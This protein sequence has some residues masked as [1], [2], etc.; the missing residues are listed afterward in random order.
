MKTLTVVYQGED[1]TS[2]MA[3]ARAHMIHP[4]SD[5]RTVSMSTHDENRRVDLIQDLLN[6]DELDQ[7]VL[8]LVLRYPVKPQT[9]LAEIEASR[10]SNDG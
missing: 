2:V 5:Y 7:D 4:R 3:E 8:E 6:S 10:E 1:L 9:T